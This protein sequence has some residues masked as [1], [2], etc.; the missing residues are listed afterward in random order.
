M[1][2]SARAPKD[3]RAG[4]GVGR[5][6]RSGSGRELRARG[7]RTLVRLLDAGATV[8][9]ARGYHA[10]RVD[11]VVKAAKTSHGTFYL[12]FSSKEDLFRALAEDAASAMVALARELPDLTPTDDGY[13]ELHA[14]L[15]RFT[16]LYERYG[17]VIRTWTEAEMVESEI[18]RIGDELVSEFSR[19]LALRVRAAAP[20]LDH[21]VAATALVAMI[22][23]SHYYLQTRQLRIRREDLLTTLT[24]VTQAGLF[25][26]AAA[27]PAEPAAPRGAG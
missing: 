8:F 20:T 14:W 7:Q 23:R 3:A 16:D 11:D 12:Y 9:A 18:G 24:S 5:T 2:S 4:N 15:E 10:A 26:A 6:G 22:E 1:A 13:G 25:G 21:R 17:A 27:R 19:Q